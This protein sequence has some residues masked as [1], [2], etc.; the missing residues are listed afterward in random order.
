M[1]GDHWHTESQNQSYFITADTKSSKR[2]VMYSFSSL[3]QVVV[4]HIVFIKRIAC[5]LSA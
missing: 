1:R 2:K 5:I 4:P 3:A